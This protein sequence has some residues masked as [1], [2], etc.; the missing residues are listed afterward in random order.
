MTICDADSTTLLS[1]TTAAGDNWR[2]RLSA[3]PFVHMTTGRGTANDSATYSNMEINHGSCFSLVF[4]VL[5]LCSLVR[6]TGISFTQLSLEHS[7][8]RLA[9]EDV[10]RGSLARIP[11]NSNDI[12]CSE[13]RCPASYLAA[14]SAD[15]RQTSSAR[16]RSAGPRAPTATRPPR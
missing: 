10:F 16:R 14:R 13:Q 3:N 1:E 5:L 4:S 9:G 8:V 12:S 2:L 11:T 15:R 7:K 6:S